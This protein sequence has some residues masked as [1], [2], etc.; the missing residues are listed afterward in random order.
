[1]LSYFVDQA[2]AGRGLATRAVAAA[3]RAR[4]R[5]ARS[6]PGRGGHGGRERRLATRA[7]AQRLHAA[8]GRSGGTSCCA[9]SG[10][11]T[12]SGNASPTTRWRSTHSTPGGRRAASGA[13]CAS[14]RA[15]PPPRLSQPVDRP[16]D[17][18]ARR[19]DRDGRRSLPGL[20]ADGLD[21]A[22][23]AARARVARAAARR[24]A[25]RRRDRRRARPADGAAPHRDRDGADH[26]ALPRQLA[27]PAPAGLGALRRCRRWPS[28]SS[29]SAGR[30]MSSLAPRLVPDEEIA[31]AGA[32]DSVYSSL[33]AV[34]GPCGR[35]RR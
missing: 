32:L 27:A 29:A 8:S 28:P 33:G 5:R 16:G 21:G 35:R 20:Q 12:C 17:L 19:C 4:L 31:A 10:P 15:A 7:R 6:A 14:T 30:R 25:G 2:R 22:R 18:D 23:R 11:T 24:A 26:G 3:A 9:A 1:M 34:G 13:G